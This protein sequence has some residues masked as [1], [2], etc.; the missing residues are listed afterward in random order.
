MVIIGAWKSG[1]AALGQTKPFNRPR[2]YRDLA[3]ANFKPRGLSHIKLFTGKRNQFSK[4]IANIFPC[5]LKYSSILCSQHTVRTFL[6]SHKYKSAFLQLSYLRAEIRDN[7][8]I[9]LIP[10]S[11]AQSHLMCSERCQNIFKTT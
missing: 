11:K 3:E 4:A 10:S 9:V 8:D 2:G 1:V 6:K 7:D 5:P